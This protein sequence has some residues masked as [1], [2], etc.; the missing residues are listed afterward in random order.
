MTKWAIKTNKGYI[1]E[2]KAVGYYEKSSNEF[3][4]NSSGKFFNT[5]TSYCNEVDKL[6][7]TQSIEEATKYSSFVGNRIQEII[8]RINAGYENINKITIISTK[9]FL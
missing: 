2:S 8:D 5:V 7:F 3:Y 4:N 9:S 1:C 6:G